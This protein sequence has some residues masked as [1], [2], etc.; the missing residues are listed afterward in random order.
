MSFEPGMNAA[1]GND[2]LAAWMDCWEASGRRRADILRYEYSDGDP[3]TM[4][5]PDVTV[6]KIPGVPVIINDTETE[7]LEDR[8]GD[9]SQRFLKLEMIDMVEASD[10]IGIGG[11]E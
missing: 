7:A 9:L 6:T 8:S 1:I 11:L 4:I 10:H 5:P 2:A 3:E